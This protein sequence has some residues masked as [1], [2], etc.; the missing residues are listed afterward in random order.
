MNIFHN[1]KHTLKNA[2][3]KKNYY[4][5]LN[6]V[7]QAFIAGWGIMRIVSAH[8]PLVKYFMHFINLLVLITHHWHYN[9]SREEMAFKLTHLYTHTDK[10]FQ[11]QRTEPSTM[12]RRWNIPDYPRECSAGGS[13]NEFASTEKWSGIMF[14]GHISPPPAIGVTSLVSYSAWDRLQV[15]L[16][17]IYFFI[18]H[19]H[20]L[21][22]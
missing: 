4:W 15:H 17:N 20:I 16:K 11:T 14:K 22:T 18:L 2:N 5:K 9:L 3:K 6:N 10:Y 12:M 21:L 19:I 13:H 7:C 8:L 1:A